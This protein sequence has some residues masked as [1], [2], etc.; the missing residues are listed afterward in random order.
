MLHFSQLIDLIKDDWR[1]QFPMALINI[2]KANIGIL[3]PP[4]ACSCRSRIQDLSTWYKD[5]YRNNWCIT[6]K[7]IIQQKLTAQCAWF[8]YLATY[9][10]YPARYAGYVCH[11]LCLSAV[12]K[13]VLTMT[14][15]KLPLI[16]THFTKPHFVKCYFN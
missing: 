4:S 14:K 16:L 2:Y 3:Y 5:G 1:I 15:P 7:Y 13:V 9:S 11:Y 12:S 10:L 8:T 6:S